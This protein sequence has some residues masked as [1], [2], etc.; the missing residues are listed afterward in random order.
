MKDGMDRYASKERIKQKGYFR[1]HCDGGSGRKTCQAGRRDSLL[2]SRKEQKEEI[3]QKFQL[4]GKVVLLKEDVVYIGKEDEEERE[5]EDCQ[6]PEEG[7][8]RVSSTDQRRSETQE[9]FEGNKKE[10]DHGQSEVRIGQP[11]QSCGEGSSEVGGS[12]SSRRRSSSRNEK[13]RQ[14]KNGKDGSSR[15]KEES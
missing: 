10:V 2:E 1:K 7:R 6:T 3:D 9:V 4:Y 11:I 14:R 12:K 8:Q 13:V 15:K 5:R